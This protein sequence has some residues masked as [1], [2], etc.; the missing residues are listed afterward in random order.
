MELDEIKNRRKIIRGRIKVED[1]KGRKDVN[2]RKNK[3][4]GKR[5]EK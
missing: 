1:K 4:Y 3:K 5:K 2:I